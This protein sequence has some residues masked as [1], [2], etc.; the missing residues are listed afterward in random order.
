MHQHLLESASEALTKIPF[1]KLSVK[2]I[3]EQA[4][5]NRNTFYRHFDDKYQ[6]LE[7]MI[8]LT[9]EKATEEIDMEA[10]RDAPFTII[11]NLSFKDALNVLDFQLQDKV[12]EEQFYNGVFKELT[13][14]ANSSEILWLLGSVQVV[15]IWNQNLKKPYSIHKDYELFDEII[16]TQK[17]P[18]ID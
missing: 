4:E 2:H 11:H 13:R 8:R 15:H 12:F 14:L 1:S 10:F 9:M 16:R 5:V 17:F 7:M 6:L 18:G 3:C